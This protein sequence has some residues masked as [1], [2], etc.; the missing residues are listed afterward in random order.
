MIS[1]HNIRTVAHYE[2]K[3]LRRSWLFRLFSFGAL[4]ILSIMNI[5]IFSPVGDEDWS[6][7]AIPSSLPLF[8]LYIINIAQALI[9]IFLASDFLKRDKKLDTNEVL[10]TRPMSN[11]EYIFGK[12][13]GILRLFLGVNILILIICLIINIISK[14]ASIDAAAY[15]EYIFIITI[16]TLIF[17]LGFAYIL[18]SIIRNQAITFLLLLG[19]A[20]LDMFYLYNRM[21]SFFDYMLFGFPVFKS[22]ITGFSNLDLILA[23]RIMYTALGLVFIF[24]TILI[25]KRLPQSRTHRIIS[26]VSLIIFLAITAFTAY[27]FLDDYYRT[28]NLKTSI[29]ETNRKYESSDFLKVT[30]ADIEIDYSKRSITALAT[31]N[32]VNNTGRPLSESPFSLNPGLAVR[33][34]DV[35]GSP[36]S[37][38]GDGHIIIVDLGKALEPD[39]SLSISFT[40]EGLVEEAYCYPWHTEDIKKDP[41]TIG[42]VRVEK[43]QAIQ[44]DNFLLLTPETH[45]YPVAGLNFYPGN[46]ARIL[47]DFTYYTLK[48]ARNNKLVAVS[49]GVRSSDNDYW[50]F[51]NEVPLTGISLIEGNYISDTI[52]VDSTGFIA[53][54]YRGHDYFRKDLNEL[55]DT[56]GN[57]ISGI[58]TELET[59][60]STEYPFNSLSLVEVPV[61]FHSIERKNTQTRAEVQPSLI[62]LPEKLATINDAGFHGTIKRQK[63]RMERNNEVITDRELQVRAFNNFVR[64]TFITSSGFRF[65]RGNTSMTPGRYLLGPSFY[66]YKNNFYSDE[67]PVINAVFETHLQ[68]VETPQRGFQRMLL[69]GLSE[70]DRANTILKDHSLKEILALNPSTDTTRL[71]LTLKGD[72]LFNLLRAEAGMEEFNNW[73]SSYLEKKK[74]RNVS[75]DEFNSDLGERFGFDLKSYLDQWYN[76]KGQPGFLFTDI[77]VNEIVVGNRTRYKVSFTAS[78]PEKTPGIFNVGFRTGRPGQGGGRGM[79]GNVSITISASGRGSMSIGMEGRGMQTNDV[80]KIVKLEAN[81]AKRISVILD[82]QPRGMFVN[83]LFSINNPGELQFPLMDLMQGKTDDNTEGEIILDKIPLMEEENEIIVDNEDP[84]FR[85]YQETSSGKLK[86]WLNIRR[87]NG[88]DYREMFIWWAPEYWQKTVESIYYGKYVKSA[89]YTRAGSGERYISW[90]ASIPEPGYYDVYTFIGKRGGQRMMMGRGG[91]G[92]NV[93]QDLHFSVEHDDGSEEMTVNWENAE[94]GWNH[95]GSYYLSPDTARVIM[96]NQSEGRTVTGDAVKWVRQNTLK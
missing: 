8:N 62:L 79:G 69:G 92:R 76:G 68:K 67:Y 14:Q 48:V 56:L 46:P 24:A 88:N 39:S 78:N 47:I 41:F 16:P 50:Y 22:N 70:N 72:Y 13:L 30:E 37:F 25:F 21:N 73:F 7:L 74:F 87:D 64:N 93:M 95:L 26:S 19:L 75:I 82:A 55:S 63:R 17:S 80:E 11:M 2:A 60:F 29:T 45:W 94:N 44:K 90:T 83:T 38:T 52:T 42:P 57:L 15:I 65:N 86:E 31:L 5:G 84:G 27:Y 20:A 12:S 10:Y 51:K 53:H 35:N 81:Q 58:M 23:Q 61:Y 4:F 32:C 1:I 66:F 36:A 89:V 49:Q 18:M 28:Q 43:R 96:T 6:F 77:I 34:I 71:I 40:Y 9:V 91:E 3:T 85:I 59:N 54:Y 33:K